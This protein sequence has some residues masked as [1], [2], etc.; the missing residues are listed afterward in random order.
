MAVAVAEDEA[1]M[2]LV[3][4]HNW[5][6]GR[7]LIEPAQEM[8]ETPVPPSVVGKVPSSSADEAVASLHHHLHRE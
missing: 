5:L 7:W 4:E 6:D 3:A 1:P 2:V 8:S